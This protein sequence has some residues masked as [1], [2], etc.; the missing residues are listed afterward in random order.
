[1]VPATLGGDGC[2]PG[3]LIQGYE[4]LA[5]GCL[6]TALIFTQHDAAVD[7]I[8]SGSNDA[9]KQRHCPA[10]ARGEQLLTVGLSQLTTSHQGGD[11]AMTVGWDGKTARFSGIMPWVTSAVK[12]DAIVTGGVLRDGQQISAYVRTDA[13]GLRIDPPMELAAMSATMTTVV[14]C[15]DVAVDACD[16]IRGPVP[17]VLSIRGTVRP[18]VVSATGLGLA[19]TM[20]SMIEEIAPRRSPEFR[21]F[22]D[23][24]SQRYQ[25]VRRDLLAAADLLGD[26]SADAPTTTVRAAV[27]DLVMRLS[28]GLMTFAKGSGYLKS[29]P[30]QR[31][32]REA[33]FFLVWSTPDCVQLKTLQNNFGLGADGA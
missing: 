22:A 16:I 10:L 1:M 31:L 30:A 27:N 14:H 28:V 3:D 21:P 9:F 5:R 23:A 12:A 2:A 8:V 33:M 11:P 18:M 29:H 24:L 13:G 19:G 20:I 4:A 25:T 32:A 26:P 6:S 15:D 7:L 17:R